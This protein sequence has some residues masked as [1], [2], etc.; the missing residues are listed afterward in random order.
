MADL[1][2]SN[3]PKQVSQFKLDWVLG[4]ALGTSEYYTFKSE[5]DLISSE[6]MLRFEIS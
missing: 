1:S 2:N 3:L 4:Q 5:E 6:F